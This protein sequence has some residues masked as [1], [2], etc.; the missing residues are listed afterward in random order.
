GTIPT[1]GITN[2]NSADVRMAAEMGYVI[3]LLA[4]ARNQEGRLFLSVHPALLS[5]EHP[6][7][8]VH[9]SMNAVSLMNDY[10]LEA[11]LYGRGAGDLPT[12]SAVM[13]D[14]VTIARARASGGRPPLWQPPADNHLPIANPADYTC[15]YFLRFTVQDRYGVLGKL[16]LIL[17]EHQVSIEQVIQHGENKDIVPIV[18]LTHLAR[19]GDIRSALAEIEKLDCVEEPTGV[20]RVEA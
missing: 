15:S 3:K 9:G 18:V 6:L 8:S 7:A 5:E 12:A 10:A 4:T 1:E 11:M 20:L 16:A 2:L 19:E 14:L 13:S 17:G